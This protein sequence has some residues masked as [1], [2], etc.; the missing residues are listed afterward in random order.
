MYMVPG[1]YQGNLISQ[2]SKNVLIFKASLGPSTDFQIL[3]FSVE[4]IRKIGILF[5]SLGF[6]S[7]VFFPIQLLVGSNF[8]SATLKEIHKRLSL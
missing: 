4:K 6:Y 8:K 1:M 2:A 3:F 7:F 5:S